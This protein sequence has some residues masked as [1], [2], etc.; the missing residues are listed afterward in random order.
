MGSGQD[1]TLTATGQITQANPER[2]RGRLYGEHHRRR[3]AL[4]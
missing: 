1:K 3:R 2:S 4:T